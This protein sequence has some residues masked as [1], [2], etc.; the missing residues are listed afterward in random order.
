MSIMLILFL[1]LVQ[2]SYALSN[3]SVQ[4][5]TQLAQAKKAIDKMVE[6]NIPTK[7]VNETYHE[8]EQVYEAQIALERM[9]KKA[10]YSVIAKNVNKII[11]IKQTAVQAS[12]ELK[13]FMKFYNESSRK[14]NLS[15]MQND[16]N[17]IISS[18]NGERFGET[19]KRIKQGYERISEL[20]YSQTT[21]NAFKSA[22]SRTL[23]NFFKKNWLK[24]LI[25]VSATTILLIIFKTSIKIILIRRKEK[26]LKLK[27]II[28]EGLIKDTQRDYFKTNK[29][30]QLQ[31]ETRLNK[32][33]EIIRDINRELPLLNEE[34]SMIQSKK[35]INEFRK[36]KRK[37]KNKGVGHRPRSVKL[38][39]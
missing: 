9:R 12:D 36:A 20:E 38:R 31:Y 39:G 8:A 25:I 3:E 22:T 27:K 34:I 11:S 10:D 7:R 14:T 13:I 23:K 30:S 29:I 16:Y 5:K 21:V 24:F 28:I 37:R 1:S 17:L 4:A 2:F 32:F 15:E 35:K 6:L 19:S 18:F 26:N 33:E